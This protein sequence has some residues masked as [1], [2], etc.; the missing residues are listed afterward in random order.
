MF[1]V[2]KESKEGVV[3]QLRDVRQ[4]VSDMS[5]VAHHDRTG[6]TTSD[7][8]LIHPNTLVTQQSISAEDSTFGLVINGHSL[9]GVAHSVVGAAR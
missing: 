3:E 8:V 4:V 7:E 9:V 1:T 6:D 5:Q 2:D